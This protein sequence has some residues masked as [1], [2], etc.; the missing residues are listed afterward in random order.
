MNCNV[1]IILF[2]ENIVSI[3]LENGASPMIRNRKNQLP[4]QVAHNVR[5]LRKL[6][7]LSSMERQLEHQPN[8]IS[9]IELT[10][11]LLNYWQSYFTS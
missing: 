2:T 10:S 3:L 9:V 4:C 5:I 8:V 11:Y 1:K 7:E 6:T